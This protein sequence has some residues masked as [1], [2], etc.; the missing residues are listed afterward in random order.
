MVQ[1]WPDVKYDT[2]SPDYTEFWNHEWTKHGT[3]S[4]LDQLTYFNAVINLSKQAG[5]P[6]LISN[7]VGGSINA[8]D[9]RN[10]YG[11]SS[12]VS[13]QCTAGTYFVGTFTCYNRNSDGTV[14][15]L[16]KCP[17]DVIAEDTCTT[18]TIS[19]ASL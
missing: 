9:L 7:N 18:T 6:S 11:G 1:Y 2:T 3:C 13:L 8:N 15:S 14:G 5:T 12:Y 4:G 10:T 19:I 17:A 16:S